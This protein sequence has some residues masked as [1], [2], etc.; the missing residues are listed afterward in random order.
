MKKANSFEELVDIKQWQEIQEHFAA[1]IGAA[2]V[3]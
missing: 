1:V 3:A 2:A